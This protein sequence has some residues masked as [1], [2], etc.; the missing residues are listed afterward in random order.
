MRKFVDRESEMET[1]QSE[2]DRVGSSLVIIYGRRRA[3]KTTLISEFI[4]DKKALFFLASEES[5]AQNRNN[6]KEKA[7][8]FLGSDLLKSSEVKNWDVIFKVIGDT[9]FDS[10]P[11]IV[12]DE[13]Q[14][15]G[16]SDP[17]FPSVFQR[18]WEE[19]LKNKSIMVILC[20]SLISMMESQTLSYN[21]PL[22]GRRTAQIRLGQIPFRYY[23][24]FYPGKNIRE[25][26]EMY[27]ITGGIPKYI[28]LFSE[29]RGVYQ[30]I[31]S[32]ILNR[33][34]YL[35]DEP[36]FLLQQEVTEIGSYFS[37]IR[38]I[39][40]GNSKLS[41]ISAALEIKATSLTKYLKTLIDLDILEREVPVT[42]ENPEKSKKGLYKIKDN[43]IRF[44]FAFVYPNMSFIESGNSRIVMDKIQKGLISRHTAF[45]YED[46]C[47]ERMWDLNAGNYWPFHF[48]KIGRWWDGKNEIDIVAADPEGNNLI[49]GECKYWYEPVGVNILHELEGKADSVDWRKKNRQVW[50]VLFSAAGFTEDLKTLADTRNDL[51]LFDD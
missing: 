20:G 36:R 39:A 4:K 48:I 21:S 35:Y 13:F 14:Y 12:I 19:I 32:S 9:A 5:E 34:S 37:I 22:Y 3:G 2:Y 11:V 31:Q 51:Y 30:S 49:L 24:E 50:Y 23:H 10:K 8:D 15:I 27:S 33:S 44:W 26:I 43:Y 41:A 6:F 46:I 29:D 47:R 17:A 38:V 40:A 25:L 45:I 1:L 18:I 42:E 16:K 7:A 28:E